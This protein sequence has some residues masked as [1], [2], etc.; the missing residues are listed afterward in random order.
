MVLPSSLS[1]TVGAVIRTLN[2]TFNILHSG[3]WFFPNFRINDRLHNISLQLRTMFVSNH[4]WT[5]R[6]YA[7]SSGVGFN[8]CGRR[9]VWVGGETLLP[10][11]GKYVVFAVI[12][13][14]W[15]FPATWNKFSHVIA[16]FIPRKLNFIIPSF[17][18]FLDE[19]KRHI[20]KWRSCSCWHNQVLLHTDSLFLA[21]LNTLRWE[22]SA[23]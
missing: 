1:C 14:R 5:L 23:R 10:K 21:N 7:F 20:E 17:N 4:R 12:V 3:S 13:S 8:L 11:G 6:F 9:W 15:K 2:E 16:I 18:Q 22:L 19:P